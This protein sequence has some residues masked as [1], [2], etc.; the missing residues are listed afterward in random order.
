MAKMNFNASILKMSWPIFIEVFLQ[1]LMGNVDQFMISHYSQQSV[2]A[3]ANA[4]QIMNVI[5][6]LLT[7]MSTATTILIA[8][9][10]GAKNQKKIEEVCTVSFFFNGVFSLA[11]S[12]LL[13]IFHQELFIWL[14]LPSNIMAEANTYL[15][16]VGGGIIFQG[17][18]FSLVAA[19]RG[20]SWTKTTMVVSL[21]MNI[22]HIVSNSILI[23]GLGPI[24]ALGV[25][26]VAISTNGNKLL[27]LLILFF[28]F[29]RY[30]KVNMSW[31]YLQPFPWKTLRQVLS[32]GIPSGGET[33]SYQLSQMTVMKMVNMFGLAVINTKVYVYILATF[34]YIYSIALA[35]AGQIIV[36]YFIGANREDI[37]GRKVWQTALLSVSICTTMTLLF[38]F[39]SDYVLRLFTDDREIL[40]LGHMVLLVEI[41]LEIGRGINIV[42]VSALQAAGD[43][44]LPVIV[45]I[46]CM[47]SFAVGL[48]YFFGIVLGMGLIGIWIGMACDECIRGIIFIFRWRSGKWKNHKYIEAV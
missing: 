2:A 17:L 21:V 22:F 8:Q 28:V 6:I 40:Q 44:K 45:G 34:C 23:F 37:V 11:A 48:S 15:T 47:W 36:G 19:F 39:G 5:I 16:I 32:I 29:R 31:K 38:Y 25:L 46:I 9:Y 7:V 12:A 20:H 27:G 35:S 42:M 1:M 4:N 3:V 10:F 41:I 43:I 33:L 14:D 18:Y 24:P 30:L 13:I 26:G